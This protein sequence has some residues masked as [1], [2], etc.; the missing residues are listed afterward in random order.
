MRRGVLVAAGVLICF[1]CKRGAKEV[2]VYTSVDQPFSEPIFKEFE[3]RSGMKVLA[4][5]DTEETKSTG[6]VNRLIAEARQPQA[7]V[8]L[9]GDPVRPFLLIK[10]G[11]VQPYPSPAAATVPAR[12]RAP[13]GTWTGSA[14]RARIL[15]VN[16][17]K[18]SAA[19][20]PKSVRDLAAP[21]WKG[22]TAL[23]NPLF[24][25]TTMHVAALFGAWGEDKGRAFLD[26]LK[27]NQARIASSNGEVKRLVTAGEV[28]F[29][30]CD[31]DDAAE[32]LHDGAPV[33]VVY[34]DQDGVGTLVMPT[35][36]VL[37]KGPHPD[38]GQALVD[39]LVSAE[40]DKRMAEL[41]A[42]MPLRADI[43]VPGVRSASSFRSMQVDYARLGDE[44]E[45][46]QPWLRQ[47]VGL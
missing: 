29:G 5:Y 3:K 46:I 28:A 6:V 15:L 20:M 24:G 31:T 30:L 37:M 9:S 13:D 35:A 7:D 25:T 19:E 12:F 41:A 32:A 34:P 23:A 43:Q 40:V 17:Q 4:V 39:W 22:Q 16:K 21:R 2:V 8:F 42:H 33:E 18:V 47:W 36:V 14:A 38:A 1:A 45:R 44:M 27:T 26:D 10:R 11:L